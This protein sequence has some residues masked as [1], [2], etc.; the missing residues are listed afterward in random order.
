MCVNA[1]IFCL[2]GVT[3]LMFLLLE[4]IVGYVINM[5]IIKD[6]LFKTKTKN[7]LSL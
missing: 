4:S 7:C 5:F 6:E 3:H 2:K 1:R